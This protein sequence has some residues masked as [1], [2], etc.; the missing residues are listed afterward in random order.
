MKV[1]SVLKRRETRIHRMFKKNRIFE[2]EAQMAIH[3][4]HPAVA[5]D[6]RCTAP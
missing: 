4:C 6:N 1:L 5:H 2:G 3:Q